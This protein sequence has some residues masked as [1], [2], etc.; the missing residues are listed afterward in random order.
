MNFLFDE[1][2]SPRLAIGLNHLEGGNSKNSTP[3]TIY[4]A[5][6]FENEFPEAKR[7]KRGIY[8]NEWI[9]FAGK[10]KLILITYDQDF[11]NLSL[12][13]SLYKAHKVGVIWFKSVKD[14]RSYWNMVSNII[15][16]WGKIK[17]VVTKDNPPF[18]Y[19][20]DSKGVQ[21]RHL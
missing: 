6:D 11:K 1:N 17:E 4:H 3:S 8:D 10:S 5:K 2:V 13:G 18:I 9:P 19:F 12:K 14:S 21:K 16:H 15:T 7:E 20:V